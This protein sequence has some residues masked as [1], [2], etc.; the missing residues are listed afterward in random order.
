MPEEEAFYAFYATLVRKSCPLRLMYL[1]K[2][3]ECQKLRVLHVF[4][5]LGEQHLGELW[6]HITRE[7]L[8]PT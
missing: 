7:G 5:E 3:V 2:L 4:G 6:Q 1:P 8:H